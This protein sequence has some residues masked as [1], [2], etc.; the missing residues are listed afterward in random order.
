[1]SFETI[2][3]TITSKLNDDYTGGYSIEWPNTEITK[4]KNDLWFRFGIAGPDEERSEIGRSA[5][6]A[7]GLIQFQVFAPK[8]TGLKKSAALVDELAA[9]FRDKEFDGVSCDGASITVAGVEDAWH[10]TNIIIPFESDLV[11]T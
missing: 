8:N 7:V 10:Q 5:Y 3:Q 11:F 9:I 1:M 2:R 4:P 6:T